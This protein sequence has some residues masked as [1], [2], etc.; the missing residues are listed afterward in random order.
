MLFMI[1][2][3]FR[4]GPDPV[5][6]RFARQGRMLPEGVTYRMSWVEPDGERRFQIMDAPYGAAL[7]PWLRAWE[8]LF[9]FAV[10]PVPDSAE[11]WAGRAWR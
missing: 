11:F 8:E 1:I 7:D 10:A 4:H 6:E 5:G 9:D 3:R 2:K